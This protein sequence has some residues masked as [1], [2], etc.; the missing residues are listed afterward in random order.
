MSVTGLRSARKGF[1]LPILALFS[2]GLIIVALVL[3]L[4]ELSRFAQGID[5]LRTDVTVGGVPVNLSLA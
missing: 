2:G 1:Q 4:L 3:F 5:V